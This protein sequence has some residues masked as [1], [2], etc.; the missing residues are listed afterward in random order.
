VPARPDYDTLRREA[1]FTWQVS[2]CDLALM[3]IAGIPIRQFNLDPAACAEAYRRGRP[4][5]REMF[6]EE[7]AL[8]GVATPPVSYG[9]VNGLGSELV[10]PEGGEVGR[11]VSQ[12]GRKRFWEHWPG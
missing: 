3:E 1:G 6:G 5:L 2:S 4:L 11:W 8:P 7:V 12:A 10:F 9:H